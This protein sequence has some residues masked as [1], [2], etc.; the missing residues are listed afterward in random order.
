MKNRSTK[1][2]AL[3]VVAAF[4]CPAV[5]QYNLNWYAD[6]EVGVGSLVMDNTGVLELASGNTVYLMYAGSDGVASGL[7]ADGYLL[8]TEEY[9]ITL[10]PSEGGGVATGTIGAEDAPPF[11]LQGDGEFNQTSVIPE[12]TDGMVVYALAIEGS[13]TFVGGA[14]PRFVGSGY[15]GDSG[16]NVYT[17]QDLAIVNWGCVEEIFHSSK[18]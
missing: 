8:D 9:V 6:L 14:T 2:L 7:D 1:L 17:I 4:A 18:V 15:W 11:N 12:S 5:A 10:D 16:G 3:A 13:A